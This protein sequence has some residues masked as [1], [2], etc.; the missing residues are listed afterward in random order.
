M[1]H[2]RHFLT[3]LE[4]S[5]AELHDIIARAIELKAGHRAG[6]DQ[7]RYP[8]RVLGM[9]FEKSSTASSRH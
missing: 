8:G 7:R 2:V 4:F 1:A 3:L 6:A 5:P 9:I